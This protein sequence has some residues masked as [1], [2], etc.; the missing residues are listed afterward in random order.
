MNNIMIYKVR[1][2]PH[3]VDLA[4]RLIYKVLQWKF[5]LVE[6]VKLLGFF[7]PF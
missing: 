2:A 4:Q 1:G 6:F 5:Y 3:H 7:R